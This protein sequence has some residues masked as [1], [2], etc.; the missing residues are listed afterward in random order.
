MSS[1]ETTSEHR[2]CSGLVYWRELLSFSLDKFDKLQEYQMVN[3]INLAKPGQTNKEG[4][5]ILS[6]FFTRNLIDGFK[7]FI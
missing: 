5:S 2:E 1:T 4:K 6:S 3:R 7:M